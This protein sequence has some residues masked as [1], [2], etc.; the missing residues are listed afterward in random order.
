MSRGQAV[1]AVE[2][3]MHLASSVEADICAVGEMGIGNTTAASALLCVFGGVPV[4]QAVGPGT[5]LAPAAIR[6]KAIVVRRALALHQPDP[7]DPIGVLSALAG[8]EIAMM[9][10]FLLGSAERRVPVMMDG[11]I[12]CAAALVACALHPLVSDYLL[13][14]HC[15]AEPG[16]A[17][18]LALLGAEPLLSL[19]LRLGE[20]TGAAIGIGILADALALYEGMATF[21]EA[22]VCGAV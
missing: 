3:G 11:F 14:S 17:R 16:H 13:F 8:Y 19:S 21:A 15:S 4:D 2:S 12:S 1:Q 6:Q 10:G 9:S 5:G 22:S 20:G 18:M 7:A